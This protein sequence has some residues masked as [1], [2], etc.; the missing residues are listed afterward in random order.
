MHEDT[1]G[2]NNMTR[3]V[4]CHVWNCKEKATICFVHKKSKKVSNA[5]YC[6]E[7]GEEFQNDPSGIFKNY[8]MMEFIQ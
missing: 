5:K 3:I 4:L 7:H 6:K 2:R 1:T 8:D